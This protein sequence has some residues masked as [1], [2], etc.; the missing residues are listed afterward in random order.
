MKPVLQALLLADR[1]YVDRATGKHIVAGVFDEMRFVSPAKM[2]AEMESRSPDRP[3][4]PGGMVAGSPY[5]FISLT[6]VRG[7]QHFD[8]RYVFLDEDQMV[9]QTRFTVRNDDPLRSVRLVAA[10]PPLPSDRAGT[11]ALELVW[12]GELLGFYRVVVKEMEFGEPRG[13]AEPRPPLPEGEP[14]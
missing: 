7:E 12:N 2:R 9:F 11:F 10:L 13:G 8:L 4:V 5:A 6:D 3:I 14:D 1:V